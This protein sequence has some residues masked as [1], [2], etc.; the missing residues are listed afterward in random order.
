M[1][2]RIGEAAR[3]GFDAIEVQFPYDEMPEL[4]LSELDKHNLPLALMNVPVGDLMEGGQGLAAIPGREN[5]FEEALA[6]AR[7][8]ADILK[9]RSINVLAGRPEPL[10]QYEQC[11]EVFCNNLKKA[12]VVTQ[13]LGIK[14]VTEP[15]NTIDL[16]G[17]FLSNSQQ[18]IDL[19]AR[20]PDIE[21]SMQYDLYHMQMMGSDLSTELP[22]VIKQIG[23][24]QFSDVPK[25]T[26]PGLGSID[27]KKIFELIDSLEY[28]GYVGA[29]YF[30]TVPTSESLDWL[31]SYRYQT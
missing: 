3:A 25:R 7:E 27:F 28:K 4:F 26:Q 22:S 6:L 29:E 16:P 24:I 20:M 23:H 9:P 21:L 31:K 17:F 10:H 19:I 15:A 1:I 5:E 13:N 30:P 2:E 14:L 12:F 8:Y 18:A 11:L